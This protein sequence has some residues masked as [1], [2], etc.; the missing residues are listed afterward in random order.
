MR[1]IHLGLVHMIYKHTDLCGLHSFSAQKVD[2]LSNKKSTVLTYIY[3]IVTFLFVSSRKK[4]KKFRKMFEKLRIGFQPEHNQHFQVT[5]P[6][7]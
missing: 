5:L 7:W 1:I 6:Y 4:T 3:H 2:N